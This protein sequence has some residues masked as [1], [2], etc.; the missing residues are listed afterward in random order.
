MWVE[1]CASKVQPQKIE[2]AGNAGR[3]LAEGPFERMDL[4]VLRV[5]ASTTLGH[6][7]NAPSRGR[8]AASR[9]DGRGS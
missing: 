8:A 5:Q 4:L 3:C 1:L 2:I 9:T 6:A 7:R